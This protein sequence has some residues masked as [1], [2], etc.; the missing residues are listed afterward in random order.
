VIMLLL[1]MNLRTYQRLVYEVP[2]AQVAFEA[3]SPK[4]FYVEIFNTRTGKKARY[5]LLGDEWQLDARIVTWHGLATVLGLDP[6]YRLQRLSGR[7][8][9]I[10]QERSSQKSAHSLYTEDSVDIWSFLK[11]YQQW[12]AWIDVAYG[13]AVYLPMV[14]KASYVVSMSRT[15]LIVR[16]DNQAA[17]DAVGQWGGI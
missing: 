12:I 6:Y 16:P 2:V 10:S 8:L 13:S 7:Y 15:G 17:S 9:N 14:D 5:E 11:D 4:R 1:A 3:V